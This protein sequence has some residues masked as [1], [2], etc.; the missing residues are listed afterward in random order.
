MI[1]DGVALHQVFAIFGFKGWHLV[2]DN[3]HRQIINF[4]TSS[5]YCSI[6][7]FPVGNFFRYSA[8]LLVSPNTKLG[9]TVTAAPE[10]LA[11]ISAL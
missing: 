4:T 2:M 3:I 7:T 5:F 9:A 6:L 11:A 10:Y 1:S 8:L